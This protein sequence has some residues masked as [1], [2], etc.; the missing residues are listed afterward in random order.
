MFYREDERQEL[1]ERNQ[2]HFA[3]IAHQY[4]CCDV[5]T[6]KMCF[7]CDVNKM[8]CKNKAELIRIKDETAYS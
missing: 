5:P 1:W 4:F 7:E 6:L 2:I 8:D 3:E